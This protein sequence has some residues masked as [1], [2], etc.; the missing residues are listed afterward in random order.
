[1][2]HAIIL[3]HPEP[4]RF[5]ASVAKAYE[6]AATELGHSAIVRDLYAMSFDGIVRLKLL[7]SF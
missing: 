4:A 2:K 3:A 6:Q 1:M 5:N 7:G